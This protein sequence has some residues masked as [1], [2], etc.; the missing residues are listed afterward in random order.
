MLPSWLPASSGCLK[1]LVSWPPCPFFFS[2]RT[3]QGARERR[4]LLG[5]GKANGQEGEEDG[6]LHAGVVCGG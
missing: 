3:V 6:G 1:T 4:L 2:F 5:G